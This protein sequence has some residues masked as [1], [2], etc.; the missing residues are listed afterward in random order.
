MKVKW[1]QHEM[2]FVTILV[3]VHITFSLV[4]MYDPSLEQSGMDAASRFKA[5]GISFIYWRNVLIPKISSTLL[6]YL[7]YLSINYFILPAIKKIS[8]NNIEKIF[9]L[10]IIKALVAIALSSYLLAIGV[11]IISY[12]AR[13]DLLSY[14]SYQFLALF[15]FNE[16]PLTNLFFGFG[17]AA[18]FVLLFTLIACLRELLIWFID[19]PGVN[20][21]FRVL[22]TNNITPLLFICLVIQFLP[23]P[24]GPFP[25]TYLGYITPVFLLYIYLTFWLFPFKGDNPFTQRSVLIRLLIATFIGTVLFMFSYWDKYNPIQFS[26][27]WVFLLFIAMPLTWLLYQQR[28]D[29]IVKLKVMET[30]LAKSTADLQ[31]LRSQINPHFLFN[32][33]N[34]LYGT[35]LKETAEDTA[36]GIQKLGDMMRFML[37]ENHLDFISMDKE[38]EYLKNYIALQKLRTQSSS[39]FIVE[40]NLDE[41]KCSR[42]IAP[43]LLI[44]F[45]ENAFKHGISLSEKSWINIRLKCGENNILFEVRNSIHKRMEADTD[46]EKNKSGIGLKNVSER[47]KLVYPDKHELTVGEDKSEFKIHLTIT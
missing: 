16:A 38:I 34:T 2:I 30:A 33:L 27:Y 12:Y 46:T 19:R 7:G 6:I 3:V 35:A 14:W 9:P 4:K 31:F 8:L 41:T 18:S 13:P 21:N 44:P 10:N 17:K 11:N 26:L 1:R 25:K 47:L 40:D 28:K 42:T 15:G 24:I 39:D 5:N 23:D 37:H 45:V 36:K 32:A 43:M 29:S 20:R 22:V